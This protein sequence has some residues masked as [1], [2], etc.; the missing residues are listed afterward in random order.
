[1]DKQKILELLGDVLEKDVS[2]LSRFPEDKPLE[3]LDFTSL[4]FIQF[5]VAFEEAYQVTVRD[6][7]L[8][9]ERYGTLSG[10]YHM[11]RKYLEPPEPPKKVLVCDC[12]HV[13]WRG[14]AGET[15]LEVDSLTRVFQN[16]LIRL[17]KKGVLLCLCSRNDP[18]NIDEAFTQLAMPLRR[19]DIAFSCVGR[20]DKA[21]GLKEIARELNLLPEALVFVDDS[22]YEIGLV[23][24]MLPEVATV[25]ADYQNLSFINRIEDYFW[26]DPGSG[27]LDRTRLYREQ[28]EREK[29]KPLF[30]TVEEY[31]ASLSTSLSCAPAAPDSAA[32]LAELSQRTNQFTL[33]CRRYSQEEIAGL[34]ADDRY[35]V[36][37]LT[38]SDKYGDMG[39]VGAAM[40]KLD[41]SQAVIESFFLSCRVFDRGFEAALLKAIKEQS[42][43]RQLYGRFVPSRKNS[44]YAD[45][46][47]ANG[48]R[49][50]E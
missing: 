12:D 7:D 45:F 8:L 42:G 37:S 17:K 49:L 39:L 10:M 3:E 25:R 30:S 5:I 2:E 11:L 44:R 14:I 43:G 20:N 15:P 16:S 35:L 40:V 18:A 24:A 21:Y 1:M 31:N 50:Y 27:S 34:L 36:L 26:Q 32:R 29:Q 46:Y 33:S 22:L 41:G 19:E 48:V 4:R 9:M 23:N 6:S 47:P 28:K 13:L 38:A